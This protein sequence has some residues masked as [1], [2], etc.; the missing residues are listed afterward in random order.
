MGRGQGNGGGW[1]STT[2]NPSGDGRSDNG[3]GK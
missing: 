3:K 1:P 2:L